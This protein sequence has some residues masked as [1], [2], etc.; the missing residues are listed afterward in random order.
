MPYRSVRLPSQS[1]ASG[2]VADR[3]PHPGQTV[4]KY[5]ETAGGGNV[6]TILVSFSDDFISP[7]LRQ[8]LVLAMQGVMLEARPA[9]AEAP[10]LR[11]LP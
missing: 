4:V 8:R 1:T 10:A 3:H 9:E 5:L 11:L 2:F 6:T 7:E